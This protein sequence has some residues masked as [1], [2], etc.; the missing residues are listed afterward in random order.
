MKS[1]I[2]NVAIALLAFYLAIDCGYSQIQWTPEQ[3]A[4]WKT[5]TAISDAFVKGDQQ[6]ANSYYDESYQGWPYRSPIPVPKANMESATAY[7]A[8]EGGK[9]LFWDAVPIVIWVK[10][11][12]AYTDYY[13]RSA[14]K[15]KDGKITNEH[16]RWLDVL[17]KKDGKWLL[18]G[19]H[20]GAEHDP[21]TK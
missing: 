17:M 4:V 19:D 10:G 2:R 5:E 12:F 3:K 15:D 21:A 8:T 13:Y 9:Y 7:Y 6:A 14:F 18:V 11:D 16:G 1:F 20:G